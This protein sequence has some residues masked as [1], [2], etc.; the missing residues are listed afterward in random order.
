MLAPGALAPLGGSGKVSIQIATDT[1]ALI[2]FGGERLTLIPGGMDSLAIRDGA[3]E[4][5]DSQ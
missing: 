5:G 1:S 2:L 4:C 3:S